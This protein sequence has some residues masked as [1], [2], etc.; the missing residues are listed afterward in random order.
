M[1]KEYITN[2]VWIKI[3]SFLKTIK[4]V[5]ICREVALRKFIEAIWWINR[6]GAQW[7]LLPS[8]Y[9][10]WNSIFKRFIRWSKKNIWEKMFNFCQENPDLEFASMDSTIVRAH[11]CAAGYGDQ[12][13]QGLGRSCGGFSTKIHAKCEAL[14]LPLTIIITAGQRA[15][16]TQAK[17]LLEGDIAEY[18][19]ADKGYDSDDFRES[20]TNR[21]SSP[22]IPGKANRSK[23]V[24]YDKHIYKERHVV[25]C[26]FSKIKYFRRVFS[27]YDKSICSYRS[28][29][30]LAGV[31]VWL[32]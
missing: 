31:D 24:E 32:R 5:Y 11:A 26:F 25:E 27:R 28:F 3:F 8:E 23:S 9:G 22:V 16:I 7:R 10:N 15:D 20:I 21:K 2:K 12:D 17:A 1:Q 6:S 18:V 13:E 29:V 19:L 14:G 30:L 4:A